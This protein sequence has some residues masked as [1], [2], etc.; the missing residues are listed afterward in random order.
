MVEDETNELDNME[1]D[2]NNYNV[3]YM[4]ED[5]TYEDFLSG[6]KYNYDDLEA[7]L[8]PPNNMYNGRG[9]C[10]RHG[11][12]QRFETVMGC[13]EVCSGMD[14]QFF[15]HITANSNEYARIHMNTNG[16]YVGSNWSNITVEEM[17]RF[18]G[19]ILKMSID[20][21]ELGGYSCYFTNK[22]TVNLGR[23]Y[24]VE[25]NDYPAWAVRVMSLRR[26]KQI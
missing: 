12:A 23:R 11:V 8:T 15:K 21:R 25:L 3:E 19:I 20:H 10:L 13:L 7:E 22:N 16:Q 4:D 18:L 26:F 5:S 17:V 14:Y 1:E 6:I 9:P 2:D 24:F